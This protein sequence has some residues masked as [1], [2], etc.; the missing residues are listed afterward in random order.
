MILENLK[1]TCIQISD[2]V[3]KALEWD[4]KTNN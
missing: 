3:R 1:D 2:N 4:G